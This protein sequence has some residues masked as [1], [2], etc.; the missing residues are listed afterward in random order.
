MK[1]RERFKLCMSLNT[2]R[3]FICQEEPLRWAQKG[4][5]FDPRMA[6]DLS[7]K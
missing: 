4:R 7:E 6:R 1:K 5:K 3:W 2:K